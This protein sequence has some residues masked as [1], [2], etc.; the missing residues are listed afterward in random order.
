MK[1]RSRR[2]ALF[3]T[4]IALVLVLMFQNMSFVE[5]VAL[6]ISPIN[7]DARQEQAQ[8]LLGQYYPFSLAR[9]TEYH[10]YLNYFLLKEVERGL[11]AEYKSYVPSLTEAIIRESSEFGFDP[12][13]VLSIIKTES[14]FNP[15]ARG[16]SGE[17][18][19]MQVRPE[20]AKWIA[21]KFDVEWRGEG[22]LYDPVYNVKIGVRYFSLLRSKFGKTAFYYIPAYNMG[23]ANVRSIR[24]DVASANTDPKEL[25]FVYS[26]KVMSHYKSTYRRLARQQLDFEK[27]YIDN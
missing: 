26:K 21:D 2:R 12:V 1:L 3:I 13:F 16:T 23:P 8:E 6:N 11:P 20:T 24:R 15:N 17:I 10:P 4:A 7:E 9:K 19:L 25:E 14:T 22:A 18:G 27:K 5:F